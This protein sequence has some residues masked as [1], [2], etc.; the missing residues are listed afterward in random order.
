MNENSL[1]LSKCT[2]IW[3]TFVHLVAKLQYMQVK[4]IFEISERILSFLLLWQVIHGFLHGYLL[5]HVLPSSSS[6]SASFSLYLYYYRISISVRPPCT[7][8]WTKMDKIY[9]MP[10]LQTINYRSG[11]IVNWSIPLQFVSLL[12]N[13]LV[14]SILDSNLLILTKDWK[15]MLID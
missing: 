6:A 3:R 9:L 2:N 8:E 15:S 11:K 10:T 1:L 12:P 14:I 7:L 5:C 13:K 4:I